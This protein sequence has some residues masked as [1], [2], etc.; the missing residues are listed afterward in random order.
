MVR[1]FRPIRWLPVILLFVASVVR[2]EEARLF[3]EGRS[4]NGELK[5]INDVPVLILSGTPEE[6]GKQRAILCGKT[7]K[8]IINYP[9]MLL[10]RSNHSNQMS[11]Y[12]EMSKAISKQLPEDYKIELCAS[13]DAAGIDRDQGILAN[14]MMDIYR[15][16]ACSSLI[17]D[18]E[19]SA[20]KGPLFGRNLDFYT[21]GILDPY[22]MVTVQRPQGKHAFATVGFPGLCGCLS[23]MNDAGLSL[24]VHESFLSRDR[25]SMFNPNGM[26]YTFCFR[27]ILEKCTT[28]EEAEQMLRAT[29]RTTPFILTVCDAKHSVV[30]EA[31]TK[32]VAARHGNNGICVCTNHFRTPELAVVK[33]C[34]RYPKLVQAENFD[35]PFTVSDVAKKM[36]EVSMG[37]M[38]V[39]TMVFEPAA[40]RLNV[41]IG[42]CPSSALPMKA[43]E[44]KPLFQP[45]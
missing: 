36:N 29:P 1:T 6:M 31:T 23:G 2:A 7:A 18:A 38:T 10:N 39:H 14:T 9:Q 22:S 19:R 43:L 41:A 11:R 20:T 25:A 32:T 3:T 28:I 42:A 21:F 35:H 40:V 12:L 17:V 26:P 30:L 5:Y 45:Q 15:S 33:L 4:G 8:Q 27:Q 16:V 34:D 13:A 24:A 44:L 37:K